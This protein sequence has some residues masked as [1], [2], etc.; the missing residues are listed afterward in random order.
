MTSV[1]DWPET[2]FASQP[3]ER[4]GVYDFLADKTVL[5]LA[6]G[7]EMDLSA[8]TALAAEL[9]TTSG[10]WK[11]LYRLAMSKSLPRSRHE[12]RFLRWCYKINDEVGEHHG[13]ASLRKIDGRLH[14]LSL[15]ALVG[16][17]ALEDGGGDGGHIPDFSRRFK[18]LVFL[19][20]SLVNAVLARRLVDQS[21]LADRVVCV[22]AD[23]T[24]LP[25]KD[26]VFDFVHCVGVI[27]HVADRQALVLEGIR[28]VN[29]DGYLV[30]GSPNRYPITRE[31]H[32]QLPLF[33]LF[34]K[35]LRSRLIYLTRGATTEE[36]TDPL[37]LRDLRHTFSEAGVRSPEIF[38][39]PRSLGKTA[40]RTPA[41][42]LF[43]SV[44]SS[45]V[46]GALDGLVNG[47]LLPIAPSHLAIV[48]GND[49][50]NPA[51]M[52]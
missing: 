17:V 20:G 13:S 23:A 28:V 32:F 51:E 12:A 5:P 38:F 26:G 31:P 40:R 1:S 52:S 8:D 9:A 49:H 25:F 27:E 4:Y 50:L 2:L 46:G 18:R 43:V 37:S 44:L 6:G 15:P 34:P 7:G 39:V 19:D 22:R 45:P 14:D 24:E 47:V 42:R 29:R 35:P 10:D 21:G 33:G 48:S 11:S 30:I 36:G 3:V 41:R 16:D